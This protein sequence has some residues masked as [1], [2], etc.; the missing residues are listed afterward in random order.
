MKNALLLTVVFLTILIIVSCDTKDLPRHDTMDCTP[1]KLDANLSYNDLVQT[2]PAT[3]ITALAERTDEFGA[4]GRNK[5][6]YLHVRF[7]FHMTR[8]ADYAIRFQSEEALVTYRDNLN[9]SFSHQTPG[10]DFEFVAPPAMAAQP[11]YQ[12]PSEGD[13]VSGTAFFAYS[14]GLSLNSL[15][16]SEWYRTSPANQSLRLEVELFDSNIRRM[17]D[18]LSQGVDLLNTVDADAPNRLLFNAIAFYSLGSY[19]NDEAA[20]ATGIAFAA[21]ALSQRDETQGYF[22]EGGGWDSSYNGV[23]AKLALELFTLLPSDSLVAVRKELAAAG[24]CAMNWQKT[25]ILPSGEV[26]TEGNTRVFP[27]G[28]EFL[29]EEKDVD[30]IKT[31]KACFYLAALTD[32]ESYALLAN[33]IIAYYQ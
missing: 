17:L 4:L 20:K 14:L 33:R 18:Y 13:L 8:L 6:G 25:R 28:E 11:D 15:Q 1:T 31:V 5:E 24:S 19:L 30:V 32:D 9:Y 26:S 10:G 23:A 16:Q 21:N 27:G 29:G 12:P 2:I 7:Q 3:V 22:I